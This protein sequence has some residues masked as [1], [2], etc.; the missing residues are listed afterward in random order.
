L[1]T[2]KERRGSPEK[3]SCARRDI[4]AKLILHIGGETREY[5]IDGQVTIGRHPGS[6]I[7]IQHEKFASRNHARV[8]PEGGECWLEDL[9]SANGTKVNGER[10]ARHLL[11]H[12]DAIQIGATRIT[13]EQETGAPESQGDGLSATLVAGGGAWHPPA[14]A[15]NVGPAAPVTTPLAGGPA[16][17]SSRPPAP[18]P[19]APPAAVQAPMWG[20]PTATGAPAAPT[21]SPAPE[22]AVAAVG[23]VPVGAPPLAAAT[24][25][26]PPPAVPPPAPVPSRPIAP[27]PLPVAPPPAAAPAGPAYAAPIPA[28]GWPAP[29]PVVLGAP[30]GFW[31]RVLAA[32]I[33]SVIVALPFMILNLIVSRIPVVGLII[34]FL[35]PFL[36]LAVNWLYCAK[37]ESSSMQA[38]FGKKIMGILVV[39][40]AG[41]RLSFAKASKRWAGKLLSGLIFGIGFLMVA[42]SSRKRGLHDMIAGTLVL[43]GRA[44]ELPLSYLW[45]G[46]L[47][48]PSS[49]A[50]PGV[51]AE[52]VQPQVPVAP[53]PPGRGPQPPA[54]GAQAEARYCPACGTKLPPAGRF[55]R[56][57]GTPVS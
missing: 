37:L 12:G 24:R 36:A 23:S 47:I 18:A 26:A 49:E 5:D 56:Q 43:R 8:V 52:A 40:D 45:Q 53:A 22:P 11:R 4:V 17:A 42:F 19:A 15:T 29:A 48:P 21:P 31:V 20:A 33:D 7:E 44:Q 55:C 51:Q 54:T 9:A 39:D 3:G 2:A 6:T 16:I 27:S 38:T 50:M 57:C 10:V 25:P 30:A 46:P 34:G 41:R 14:A 32:I 13:F 1:A 28:Q 35:L